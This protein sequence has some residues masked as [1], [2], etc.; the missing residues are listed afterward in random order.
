MT[1]HKIFYV[2]CDDLALRQ[3]GLMGTL[4]VDV[5]Q[6]LIES[7]PPIGIDFG[8]I[9]ALSLERMPGSG[10]VIR[11]ESPNLTVFLS[12]IRFQLFQWFLVVNQSRTRAL[13]NEL[14]TRRA[15]EH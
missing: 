10:T 12:I 7:E 13:F 15:Q 6:M 1:K 4:R 11:I 2:I 14:S 8:D 9:S 3:K 5:K